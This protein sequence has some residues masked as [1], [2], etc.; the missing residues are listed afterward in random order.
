MYSIHTIFTFPF[1]FVLHHI[2]QLQRHKN[3]LSPCCHKIYT[4]IY[5][6]LYIIYLNIYNVVRYIQVYNTDVSIHEA[7]MNWF[8]SGFPTALSDIPTGL[9]N[10]YTGVKPPSQIYGLQEHGS[11]SRGLSLSTQAAPHPSAP[12]EKRKSG[13]LRGP[14]AVTWH[15]GGRTGAGTQASSQAVYHLELFTPKVLLVIFS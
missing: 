4:Y 1:I 9:R 6:H 10:R 11:G 8:A 7:H 3:F 14:D 5:I 2:H 15:V 12:T 13:G